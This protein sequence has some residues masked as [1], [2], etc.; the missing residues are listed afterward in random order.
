M[1]N[2]E[3]KELMD[4][5]KSTYYQKFGSI[6][7]FDKMYQLYKKIPNFKVNQNIHEI[8]T[9]YNKSFAELRD[10]ESEFIVNGGE[11]NPK[12]HWI[13][14]ESTHFYLLRAFESMKIDLS[15]PNVDINAL[16]KGTPGRI[17]KMWCGN[18]P[19]DTTELL[20]GR[21][22]KEPALSIFPNDGSATGGEKIDYPVQKQVDIVAVCSH[23]FLPFSSLEPNSR[24]VITY[25]P[26][27]YVIGISKLQRFANWASRRGWLQE[28]L[29]NY[30]G[31]TIKRIAGTDD[32]MIEMYG[33]VHGCEKYRGASSKNGNLTTVYK[34]GVFKDSNNKP[35]VIL[36]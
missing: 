2:L 28:D 20:S 30:L 4:F 21:W 35:K 3:N 33:L 7:D 19:T 23:H 14:R 13:M 9:N 34:S 1:E 12:V 24:V 36:D 15:D 17:A 27:D 16:G 26:K 18:D 8:N 32:V 25:I 6:E 31:R 22:C 10:N 11:L 5:L 29:C